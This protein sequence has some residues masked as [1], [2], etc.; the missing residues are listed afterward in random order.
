M[1]C[2]DGAVFALQLSNSKKNF[3][4]ISSPV[5]CT[6]VACITIAAVFERGQRNMVDYEG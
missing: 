5:R 3:I 1:V 4:N 6:V 2:D